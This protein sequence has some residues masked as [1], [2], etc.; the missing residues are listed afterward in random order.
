MPIRTNEQGSRPQRRTA[1]TLVALAVALALAAAGCGQ[2][3]AS[4][5]GTTPT[6]RTGSSALGRV[7]IAPSGLTLYAFSAES[8]S[9]IVCLSTC[10]SIW[11]P[12]VVG[13]GATP[14]AGTGVSGTIGTVTRPG[15]SHQVTYNGLLLYTYTGDSGPGQ[16]EGQGIVEQYGTVKG[17]WSAV[18]P[19]ASIS[20]ASSSPS[21]PASPG[22][23]TYNY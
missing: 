21:T 8:A 17:T 12:L 1:G 13:N 14:T 7:L 10:A 6:V 5:S 4:G 2:A 19:N 15:G 23:T 3:A 11:P 20:A 22:T 18:T 9:D 16:T